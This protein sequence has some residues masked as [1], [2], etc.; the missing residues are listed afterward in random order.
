M[1]V[2]AASGRILEKVAGVLL[3][4]DAA[5]GPRAGA[6]LALADAFR[7]GRCRRPGR[8]RNRRSTVA[9]RWR[10]RVESISIAALTGKSGAAGFDHLW[11]TFC[12]LQWAEIES[13]LRA[14]DRRGP[15]RV[16]PGHRGQF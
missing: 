10:W 1:G 15:A 9:A 8:A 11:D 16:R 12:V 14:L 4:E 5:A 7:T 3:G 13:S 2:L 6:R